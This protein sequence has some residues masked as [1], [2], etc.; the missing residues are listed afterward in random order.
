M[1]DFKRRLFVCSWV[2]A[3]FDIVNSG[4][5]SSESNQGTAGGIRFVNGISAEGR[6]LNTTHADTGSQVSVYRMQCEIECVGKAEDQPWRT[7]P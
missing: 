2:S 7:H 3:H 5:I 1:S 4:L 6:V